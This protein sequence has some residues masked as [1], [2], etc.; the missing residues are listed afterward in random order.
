METDESESV[1]GAYACSENRLGVDEAG[2]LKGWG[3][4]SVGCMCA[5]LGA[6]KKQACWAEAELIVR[7]RGLFFFFFS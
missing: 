5:Q 1:A 6:C 4:C 3:P 7:D 2:R